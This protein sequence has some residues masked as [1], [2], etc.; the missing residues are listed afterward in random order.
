ME[1]LRLQGRSQPLFAWGEA[2]TFPVGRLCLNHSGIWKPP[3]V[4]V[5]DRT[6]GKMDHYSD[7]TWQFLHSLA[8]FHNSEAGTRFLWLQPWSR[9]GGKCSDIH[10]KV[11][12]M[13][14]AAVLHASD[15]ETG[16]PTSQAF[17][18]FPCHCCIS[19][20]VLPGAPESFAFVSKRCK[21]LPGSLTQDWSVFIITI[22]C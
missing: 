15:I 2:E 17:T 1:P 3:W 19:L 21:I 22:P 11:Q 5:G 8:V 16:S 4:S 6:L 7:G 12:A 14:P 20:N 9:K 10:L 13:V 18:P